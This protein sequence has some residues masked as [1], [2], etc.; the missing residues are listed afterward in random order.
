MVL[1]W[2]WVDFKSKSGGNMIV[3]DLQKDLEDIV[4]DGMI[5]VEDNG[6]GGLTATKEY[7]P[8]QD[9]EA[10]RDVKRI[11]QYFKDKGINKKDIY[12]DVESEEDYIQ[13][14]VEI[15]GLK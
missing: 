2:C 7:E 15:K 13:V 1:S 5:N 6:E 11:K 12:V 9:Y 10:E 8:S 3:K 14:N 4:T